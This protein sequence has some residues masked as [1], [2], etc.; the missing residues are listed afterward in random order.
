MPCFFGYGLAGG[1]MLRGFVVYIPKFNLSCLSALMV[2]C[3]GG[4]MCCVDAVM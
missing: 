1:E 4:L 3:S 2:A